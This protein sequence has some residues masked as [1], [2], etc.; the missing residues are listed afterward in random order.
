MDDETDDAE[1]A[2]R[3][4]IRRRKVLRGILFVLIPLSAACG[5]VLLWGS[6]FGHSLSEALPF[7]GIIVAAA[8]FCA[9][10]TVGI[11]ALTS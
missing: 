8:V 10:L 4:R 9:L 6:A 11:T 1:R 3:R 2:F 5:Y 7:L